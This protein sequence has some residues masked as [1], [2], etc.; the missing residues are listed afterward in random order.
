[1]FPPADLPDD[2]YRRIFLCSP[3]AAVVRDA[4]G[5]ILAV[6]TAFEALFGLEATDVVGADL[7]TVLRP[8]GDDTPEGPWSLSGAAFLRETRWQAM[9][10][11]EETMDEPYS[12]CLTIQEFLQF[13]FR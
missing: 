13:L 8:V 3:N 10:P 6:N 7:R 2:V 12:S 5:T 9:E 1:M 11:F 4:D